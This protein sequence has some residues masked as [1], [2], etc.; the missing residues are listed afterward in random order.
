MTAKTAY[1]LKLITAV[2]LIIVT[3][4][5]FFRTV[6]HNPMQVKENS[7]RTIAVVNEDIGTNEE[8]EA[9]QFGREVVP[10]LQ[11]DSD[12]KWT[13]LG[14]SAAENG[15]KN[16]KYDAVVYIPSDFSRKIMSYDEQQPKKPD[17]GYK[18][19]NQLTSINKERAIREVERATNRVNKKMA[20]LYWSYVAMDMEN[21]RGEFDEILE[22]EV[23]FQN[24]M[25]AFYKPSSKNLAAELEQ[26]KK[27]LEGIRTDISQ[28]GADAPDRQSNV[29]QFE[30][31]LS[32][33]IE[34]VD[35]YRIYQDKQ[36][37]ILGKIQDESIAAVQKTTENQ[38]PRHEGTKSMFAEKTDTVALGM[39]KVNDNLED[40]K[41]TFS[42]LETMRQSQV[43]RQAK[44]MA[45]VQ[46]TYLDE[47]KRLEDTTTLNLL[48]DNMG[49][50]RPEL[51]QG[52]STEPDPDN[53]GEPG[54]DPGQPGEDDSPLTR[55]EVEDPAKLA[56][57]NT[58]SLEDAKNR[59]AAIKG[60]STE[61][62]NSLTALLETL[63]PPEKKRAE[64]LFGN[65][66]T[67]STELE[68]QLTD[69][70]NEANAL[71]GFAKAL[72]EDYGELYIYN[73]SLEELYTDLLNENGNL[74]GAKADLEEKNG[75]LIGQINLFS[76]NVDDLIAGILEKEA[77][78][79]ASPALSGDRKERLQKLTEQK[80]NSRDLDH[81]I[82]YYSYL[83]QYEATLEGMLD[84]NNPNKDAVLKNEDLLNSINKVL[85]I[86]EGEK[87]I[88]DK[89]GKDLPSTQDGLS[90]LQDQFTLFLADYT[91]TIDEQQD[92]I[93]NDLSSIQESA[94][95]VMQQIQ[96]PA[97]MLS[98]PAPEPNQGADDSTIVSHQKSIGQEM[99]RINDWMSSLAGNQ[100]TVVTY[101]GTLQGKVQSVQND[102]DALNSKWAT[103]VATTKQI[104]D[105]VFSVMGNTFV[106]GQN[107]GYVYDHLSN[108]LNVDGVA[109]VKDEVKKI[110]PV[111][112]L[113]IVLISSLLIGYFSHYFS[114]AP[115][116]VQGAMFILLNLIVGLIISLFGLNIYD[117]GEERSIEWSIF[118][119]LL[120]TAGSAIVRVG[121]ALGNFVG[122]IAS[123][124]LVLFFVS[125][126]LALTVP[127]ID[128]SDPMSE[129]YM[130]IQYGAQ[131][132]FGGAVTVLVIMLAVLAAIPFA[133]AAIRNARA[134]SGSDQVNEA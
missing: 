37:E 87:S 66:E 116:L 104:R 44:D 103:N 19:Q 114:N 8:K 59:T 64:E 2:I 100:E 57:P 132:M 49:K 124:A 21:V 112:I 12:Y 111:V 5:A 53:P 56:L 98:A 75:K 134:E 101:T 13:V 45:P 24:T 122:W 96:N 58:P 83:T 52:G 88:W 119:I 78:I 123:V 70:Q 15:L 62:K 67:N 6:G 86:N 11:N 68:T 117:L 35:A 30:Q 109:G 31:N 10:L 41:N 51:E 74:K 54:E 50:L 4:A 94:S 107:N 97:D 69:R 91:K 82:K 65:L 113:V 27:M 48:E 130:S 120:L 89:F 118:T 85:A 80:I 81:I 34:Y 46:S 71:G 17:F 99:Q 131:S 18:V 90:M 63:T 39:Q 1:L 95:K 93:M 40:N 125:P 25:V 42:A 79:L 47:Y 14:R 32:S 133:A 76:A 102:A 16:L 84:G 129:V 38:V 115:L 92:G 9:L 73:K 126:L 60:D 77:N 33:F 23:S 29:Q 72:F 128:Y 22:K 3:P 105:D 7:T 106:D 108:P 110:P 121:F 127:N 36:Q 28:T 20:S 55:P 26:Q 43:D 61:L